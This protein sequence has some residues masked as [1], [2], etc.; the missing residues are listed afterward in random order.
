MAYFLYD[1]TDINVS[2]SAECKNCLPNIRYNGQFDFLEFLDNRFES[3]YVVSPSLYDRV[4]RLSNTK[5]TSIYASGVGHLSVMYK[6]V[7][8]VFFQT[9][10]RDIAETLLNLYNTDLEPLCVDIIGKP[11]D[12]AVTKDSADLLIYDFFICSINDFKKMSDT[13]QFIEGCEKTLIFA[14]SKEDILQYIKEL[15]IL[16]KC[17]YKNIMAQRYSDG[18]KRCRYFLSYEERMKCCSECRQKYC[19]DRLAG[20]Y[21]NIFSMV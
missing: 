3:Q 2:D 8:T 16:V 11:F 21:K 4:A 15:K 20:K 9:P 5:S 1:I 7:W 12:L 13:F 17:A 19:K 10:Y 14:D 18:Y 6:N